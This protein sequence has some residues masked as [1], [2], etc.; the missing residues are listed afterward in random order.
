MR[1]FVCE[2]LTGGGLCAGE[3]PSA[4]LRD[5]ACM[6]DA[7]LA[8]LNRIEGLDV[9][10]TRDVRL[11]SETEKATSLGADDDPWVIW[12]ECLRSADAAWIVAPESG[13]I[14]LALRH[15]ADACRCRFIGCDAAAIR[16][17][18][19]KRLAASHFSATGIDTIPALSL[20]D[21]IPHSDEGWVVKPDD[22]AGCEDSFYFSNTDELDNWR[23]SCDEPER[24][25]LQPRMRGR[26]ASLSVLYGNDGGEILASNAQR[27]AF[28]QQLR[29]EGVQ[30][31][32]PGAQCG[33]YLPFITA[34][35]N[36]LPGLSGYVGIDF[37]DT[38]DGPVLV[39]VNPRLTT[40][41]AGLKDVLDFNPAERILR[42]F[43]YLSEAADHIN[44]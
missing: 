24:Y 7:L 44:V 30:S 42:S 28:A 34:V 36:A 12:S 41:Y 40:S 13:G 39:E 9:F 19:S 22:G 3:L 35:G 6:A 37:I 4:L 29:A 38:D 16:I 25:I 5:A 17:A 20:D 8:D 33:E 43:G 18:G 27:I 26:H 32:R 23:R 2:F 10:T 15:L 31:D 21:T 11:A 14:L 1:L